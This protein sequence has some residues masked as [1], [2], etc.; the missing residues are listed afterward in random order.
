MSGRGRGRGRGGRAGSRG[1]RGGRG[2]ASSSRGGSRGASRGGSR[3]GF[4]PRGGRG[5]GPGGDPFSGLPGFDAANQLQKLKDVAVFSKLSPKE[6]RVTKNALLNVVSASLVREPKFDSPTSATV[7]IN[8]LVTQIAF[9]DP[10]FILKV[11]LYMRTELNIRSTSNYVVSLASN[12]RHCSPFLR[13]YC[14]ATI[15]LP[16]DWLDIA[17][18]YQCLPDK[19]LRGNALP[20]ALRKALVDK[21]PDF[22]VYQLGKYNKENSLKRKKK[23]LR[24]KAEKEPTKAVFQAGK[25]PVTI[26]QLVRQLH[27]SEPPYHV[28]CILGKKYPTTEEE[29]KRNRLPGEFQPKLAGTRMKFPVPETWETLLSQKGNR[30]STWEELIEHK[31]LPF[32]AML[33]NL[34]NLIFTGVHPRYHKWVMNKLTNEG[35]IANSKQF[36]FR[37][38]SAYEVIPKD[39]NDFNEQLDKMNNP[40][41][42]AAKDGDATKIRRKKKN[43]IVPTHRPQDDLFEK[44]RAA[45]DTAVKHATTHN[46]KPIRGST[47]VFCDGSSAM[48]EA[49]NQC[50]VGKF[51]QLNQLGILLGLMCKYVC[52][53]CDFR[54]F[55]GEVDGSRHRSVTLMEGTILENMRIVEESSKAFENGAAQF[56]FDYFEDLIKRKEIID[57]FIVLSHHL[58]LPTEEGSGPNTI[59][60]ILHKYRQEVNPR[61]LF[62][63]VDL[64]GRGSN[65]SQGDDE[66]PNDILVSGFSDAILRFIAERGDTNQL[67]YVEH[68]DIAHNLVKKSTVEAVVSPL[69]APEPPKNPLAALEAPKIEEKAELPAPMKIF[70]TETK[71]RTCR[72]FISSTFL[73]MHGERDML[74]RKVF[75]ELRD[76]CA[77]RHIHLYEVDLRWGVTEH[78][79]QQDKGLELCL[80]EVQNCSPFFIGLVGNRYGWV[81]NEYTVPDHERFD[82]VKSYPVGR[83]VTEL[84]MYS[85][86]IKDSNP[87]AFFYFRNPALVSEIPQEHQ[88]AFASES[89]EAEHRINELKSMIRSATNNVV[90]YNASWRGI[91]DGKPMTGNLAALCKRITEDLWKNITAV[92]P[93]ESA[94]ECDA[95]DIEQ[96]YHDAFAEDRRKLFVGRKDVL[97]ELTKWCDEPA[98]GTIILTGPPGCGKSSIVSVF[99]KQYQAR[100]Q[101]V[102][103]LPFFVGASPGSTDIRRVLK[104]LCMH[105]AK[106]FGI[107]DPIP[108]DYKSLQKTFARFLEQASYIA[109]LVLILDGVDQL[110]KTN[111]AHSLDWLPLVPPAKVILTAAEGPVLKALS[112]RTSAPTNTNTLLAPKLGPMLGNTREIAVGSLPIQDAKQVVQ[113]VLAEYH[114]KLEDGPM[115]DQ[116]RVL[117]KKGDAGRPL[118]LT[119]ACEELRVFGVFEQLTD[120]IKSL[121]PSLLKLYDEVLARLELDH[122]HALV[123]QALSMLACSRGGLREDEL[124]CTL[125]RNNDEEALPRAVWAPLRHAL[126]V[127]VRGDGEETLDFVHA[128]FKTAVEKKYLNPVK[129]HGIHCALAAYFMDKADPKHNGTY[130]G[131]S[132]RGVSELAYHL[133]MAQMWP[134]LTNVLTSLHYIEKKCTMGLASDLLA[135]YTSAVLMGTEGR[136]KEWAGMDLVKQFYNFVSNSIHVLSA[137]PHLTFQQ[138]ANQ[139]DVSAVAKA[140]KQLWDDHLEKRAWIKW[141]NKPQVLDLCRLTVSAMTDGVTSTAFSADGQLIVCASRDC[142]LKVF[143]VA[144]G[145][146]L[147]TL[148][149]HSSPVIDCCFSPDGK[150][151]ASA[152]WDNTAKI[153]D[154]TNFIVAQTLT[155]HNERLSAVCFTSDSSKVVTAAWDNTIRVWD[156]TMGSFLFELKGHKRPINS[157]SLVP[158]GNMITSGSWDGELIVWNL[159]TK[160]MF[161]KLKGHEKSIKT[162]SFHPNA[163]QLICSSKDGAIMLWDAQSEKRVAQIGSHALPTNCS[164]YSDIGDYVASASDDGSVKVWDATLGKETATVKLEDNNIGAMALSPDERY[165]AA[166]HSDTTIQIWDLTLL[167]SVRTLRK[168]TQGVTSLG[169]RP[170]GRFICCASVDATMS[171]WD[172]KSWEC[173]R[174]L[175]EHTAPVN[176]VS[177][178]PNTPRMVSASDDFS[179]IMWDTNTWKPVATLKG[180]T[181]VVK[182]CAYSPDG[183]HIVS[184]ARDGTIRVWHVESGKLLHTMSG[185]L[186][187]I[188]YCAWSP[189]SKKVVTG[190]WDFNCK[191]WSMKKGREVKAMQGHGGS[192]EVCKYSPDG[193]VIVTGSYDKSMKVWDAEGGTEIT[194]LNGHGARI[195]CFVFI[196]GGKSLVSAADDNT[197]KVWD[198]LASREVATLVGHSASVRKC[199]FSPK[200]E[201]IATASDDGTVKV[202]DWKR[203]AAATKTAESMR[204]A[205]SITSSCFSL[206]GD[207]LCTCASDGSIKLW[208]TLVTDE[209]SL[210]KCVTLALGG[211]ET[212]AVRCCVFAKGG[213]LATGN[214]RGLITLWNTKDFTVVGTLSGHTNA[215][216][217][218]AFTPDGKHLVSVSWDT[219]AII[220]SVAGLN[221]VREVTAHSEWLECVDISPDGSLV[222]TGGRDNNVLLWEF[223]TGEVTGYL[224]GHTQWVMSL[225]LGGDHKIATASYDN[226]MRFWDLA[227]AGYGSV[228]CEGHKQAVTC[229]RFAPNGRHL[230]TSSLDHTIKLW[231][232]STPTPKPVLEFMA[233]SP[234][235]SVSISL[236]AQLLACGD[237]LG[238][239]YLLK[240]T[241]P[242]R[243]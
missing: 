74:T 214:D 204:H 154:T 4:G 161:K 231:D 29:F 216:R 36:P 196:R 209:A 212:P 179:L 193:K 238:N 105:L 133:T 176:C 171:V 165:L 48:R 5:G 58:I 170:D 139:P 199:S 65:I 77:K 194:A 113:G 97:T 11:A 35:T 52:E 80:D 68:I 182:C 174:V 183:K 115:N 167:K 21:F 225:A 26:K 86:A 162:C 236:K 155:G 201:L 8:I 75:P 219:R 224:N 158:N 223:A 34:R 175:T 107:T 31:K 117:L 151:I 166:A 211:G 109:R 226:T 91:V 138:A 207:F 78:E 202:W 222:A 59:P 140:A 30:S 159:D 63:S 32:M 126:R 197:L 235:T 205:G 125:K 28:M 108:E 16:S 243:S 70:T 178:S 85:G 134:Q 181:A 62:V 66:H 10:E 116:L 149:S 42:A 90:T 128:Q 93:E 203:Q 229:V 208:N 177:F 137:L 213:V 95:L 44:Y 104:S 118:Y 127:F 38:F 172:T 241:R 87:H 206:E 156:A 103:V 54:I 19:T 98:A 131:A 153:W 17:S 160:E 61:M 210:G 129:L 106:R 25:P 234:C 84:E 143:E 56:P 76:R 72:V 71:W 12:I 136:S 169:Y 188:N 99:A 111:R 81:P 55:G 189:D 120:K 46:V 13:K 60:S 7:K 240:Y 142:T 237:L 94:E 14:K 168:H 232:S 1:G 37:F 185:H 184:I 33:R 198:L 141:V 53:D 233:V 147:A 89:P 3:G 190:A 101:K 24:L 195:N 130:Q 123:P 192:V 144:T 18:T 150:F 218:L 67:Q 69:Y 221:Q 57:N 83:S 152:A 15:R 64:S 146:E 200:S 49:Q 9:Y 79:T 135:D 102:V 112:Q 191:V 92:F 121:P 50:G 180:H 186:D 2:G 114:K 20:T 220:W 22:D 47:V 230:I 110:D 148:K 82:W 157:L 41:K 227:V 51:N 242:A 45:L 228:A 173:V 88:R 27:I 163:R 217:G 6:L 124:L 100:K 145:R 132:L 239:V 187:W 43:P 122:G 39:L 23:K 164:V 73:D 96:A 215:V 40:K 119:V